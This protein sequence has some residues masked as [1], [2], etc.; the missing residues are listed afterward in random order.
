MILFSK[1]SKNAKRDELRVVT[2]FITCEMN[3]IS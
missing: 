3:G 2:T 1:R